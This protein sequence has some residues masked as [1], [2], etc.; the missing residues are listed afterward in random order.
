MRKI[1]IFESIETDCAHI[2]KLSGM[3]TFTYEEIIQDNSNIIH[4]LVEEYFSNI[5]TLKKYLYVE[6]R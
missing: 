5:I 3:V 6:S 2:L 1:S 4:C